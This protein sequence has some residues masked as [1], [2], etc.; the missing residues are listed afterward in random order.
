MLL[1]CY[2]TY[3]NLHQEF[4]ARSYKLFLLCVQTSLSL[5][6]A[7]TLNGSIKIDPLL[8]HYYGNSLGGVVGEV[9]M[10]STVE[11]ERGKDKNWVFLFIYLFYFFLAYT[12]YPP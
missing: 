9:Y 7:V 2:I 1:T 3:H 5:D 6:P 12:Y 4:R 10:A 11:V 8:S